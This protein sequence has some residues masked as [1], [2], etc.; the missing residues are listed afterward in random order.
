[1]SVSNAIPPY[2]P[3]PKGWGFTAFSDKI[4]IAVFL[5]AALTDF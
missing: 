4:G 1:M 5:A 2:I 3:K